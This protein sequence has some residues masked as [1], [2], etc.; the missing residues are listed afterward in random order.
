MALLLEE[1]SDDRVAWLTLNRPAVKNALDPDLVNELAARF[2]AL[3]E[4]KGVRVMVL[5]G[6]GGAFCSGADLRA[7]VMFEQIGLL[8]DR[9]HRLVHAI[10]NAPQPVI[11]MVDGPAA[12]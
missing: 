5:T 1:I 10:A 2:E 8:I 9:Y 12:G 7:N 3:A 6:A 4:D 11:A